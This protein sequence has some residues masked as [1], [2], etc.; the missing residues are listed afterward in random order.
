MF[1]MRR[2]FLITLGL[3][4]AMAFAACGNSSSGSGGSGRYGSGGNNNQT[5]VATSGGSGSSNMIKTAT[6]TV[7][8]KSVTILINAQGMTLYYRTSDTSSSVCSGNCASIWPPLLVTGSNAPASSTTL[9]AKLAVE[10]DANG[11]QV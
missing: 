11:N 1:I 4:I 8:G 10:K 3:V 7:M 2:T 9:P 6:A 5:P